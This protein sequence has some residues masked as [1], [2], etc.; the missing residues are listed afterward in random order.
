M[1]V[2]DGLAVESDTFFR[3]QHRTLPEHGFETA[4]AANDVGDLDLTNHLIATLL[5]LLEQLAFGGNNRLQ[6]GL[7]IWLGRRVSAG[8]GESQAGSLEELTA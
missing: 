3:I 2:L 7:E 8:V 1:A 6:S 4:H 5:D